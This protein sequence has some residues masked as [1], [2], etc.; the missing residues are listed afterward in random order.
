MKTSFFNQRWQRVSS[1]VASYINRTNCKKNDTK[2]ISTKQSGGV[3]YSSKTFNEGTHTWKIKILQQST[4]CSVIG[5]WK[6]RCDKGS[7]TDNRDLSEYG[8]KYKNEMYVWRNDGYKIGGGEYTK[9]DKKW[10]TGDVIQMI[11]D[12]KQRKLRFICN[13]VDSVT[14]DDIESTSY[15]VCYCGYGKGDSIEILSYSSDNE[16]KKSNEEDVLK[17]TIKQLRQQNDTQKS[18]MAMKDAI[19]NSLNE[20]IEILKRDN[21]KYSTDNDEL[22][23]KIA[24]V[25]KENNDL[26]QKYEI[27]NASKTRLNEQIKVL[28]REKE[29]DKQQYKTEN[30]GLNRKIAANEKIK[31]QEMEELQ[32]KNQNLMEILRKEKEED[33]QKYETEI[34]GLNRKIARIEKEKNDLQQRNIELNEEQK[35]TKMELKEVKDKYNA[36]LRKTKLDES[37]YE[38]W[39]CELIT[40]WIISLDDNYKRYEGV[41]RERLK[42]EEL[43][44]SA[45]PELEKNDLHRFGITKFNDKSAIMKHIKR[46]IMSKSS[47]QEYVQPAAPAA[48]QPNQNN[49]DGPGSTA[50]I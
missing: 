11:L 26:T 24:K 44:G 47:K 3:V 34:D 48:Y 22:N 32:Q 8:T 46:V 15:C 33:K 2:V 19:V 7:K 40:D 23:R 12:F 25:Q 31:R 27:A 9:M 38:E 1:I 42:E 49:M 6:T 21:N 45:F 41:L 16:E 17:D 14:F 20:Q 10:K 29:K 28:K 37:K 50:Y 5:I 43:D 4:W 39:D 30:D 35:E 36:L 18:E 13:G